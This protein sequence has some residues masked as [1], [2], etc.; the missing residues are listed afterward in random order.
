MNRSPGVTRSSMGLI[1]AAAIA[2]AV[3]AGCDA[4]PSSDQL[5]ARAAY[6]QEYGRTEEALRLYRQ[7]LE[8][9]PGDPRANL[10]VGECLLALGRP[11]EALLPLQIA[12][13]E[14]PQDLQIALTLAEALYQ[15]GE[16]T[17]LYQ[18]LRDRAVEQRRV[19]AWLAMADYAIKLDDPD[20][21]ATAIAAALELTGGREVQPYI[22]AAR[23]A[24]R[25]GDQR[26]AIR[27]LRQAY[28]VAPGNAVVSAMLVEYGEVPGP[29]IALPPGE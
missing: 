27:R 8:F 26:E 14:R 6:D 9:R 3:L 22:E 25:I 5:V 10:G 24:E 21:A 29:T 2:M 20:T 7:V 16:T 4:P 12:S 15:S 19:E 17:K 1:S 11:S 28:G 23:L 18:L 13:V